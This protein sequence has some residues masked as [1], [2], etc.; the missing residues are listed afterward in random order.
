MWSVLMQQMHDAHKEGEHGG[1][2]LG[3]KKSAS[4]AVLI[5]NDLV[6]RR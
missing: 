6:G 4:Y 2:I 5:N 1:E 3:R